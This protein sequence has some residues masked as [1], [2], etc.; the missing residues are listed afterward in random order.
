M[1]LLYL[2]GVLCLSQLTSA[3]YV[4]DVLQ[5]PTLA[6]RDYIPLDATDVRVDDIKVVG[7]LGDSIATA[8]G[9]KGYEK[10]LFEKG[11]FR[12]YR[13]MS[14]LQGGDKRAVTIPNLFKHFTPDVVGGSMKDRKISLCYGNRLCPV[15]YKYYPAVD[16]LNAAQSGALSIQLDSELDYLIPA[17]KNDPNID[18]ENDWKLI[19]VL[20]GEPRL[21]GRMVDLA[22]ERI[23]EEVPN[24]IVNLI[25]IFKVSQAL[26]ITPNMSYCNP[27]DN[28]IV[29]G[30]YECPCA[31]TKKGRQV[32]DKSAEDFNDELLR[33]YMKYR[34][35]Q[36]LGFGVRFSYTMPDFSS[37]PIYALSNFDCFHPGLIGH[38]YLAKITW[39][40]LFTSYQD[41]SEQYKWN[42][43]P[44]IYCPTEDDRI[45]I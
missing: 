17:M 10:K 24:A 34:S 28:K 13:S 27:F 6:P 38:A 37:W 29:I 42:E 41:V 16:N 7:T 39:N 40:S 21:F 1:K 33:V 22:V 31:K 3:L 8:F 4:K 11:T 36:R 5:C 12:E 19:N 35:I 20:V 30:D 32:M 23:M 44:G 14:F 45:V 18:Y 9:L 15:S 26:E 43:F 2:L 25:A